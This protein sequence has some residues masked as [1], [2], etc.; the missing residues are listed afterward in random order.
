MNE[1]KMNKRDAFFDNY[2][3]LLI[4]LVVI[5]HFLSPLVL[6]SEFANFI[7]LIGF[8]VNVAGFSF[9]SG[10]FSKKK[11]LKKIFRRLIFP[12]IILQLTYFI[13][14]QMIGVKKDFSL[15]TTSYFSLWYLFSLIVW[16]LLDFIPIQSNKIRIAISLIL[17]FL[18]GFVPSSFN[19]FNLYR[20]VG[21][22]PFFCLGK[23]FNYNKLK[24]MKEKN[25]MKVLGVIIIGAWIYFLFKNSGSLYSHFFNFS[26]PYSHYKFDY[27]YVYRMIYIFIAY[28]LIWTIGLFIPT[29][30]NRLTI[31]G[32]NSLN[33]YLLH[34]F[35]LKYLEYKT[36]IYDLLLKSNGLILIYILS[37][38]GI[39]FLLNKI[40]LDKW[41]DKLYIKTEE[42]IVA[43]KNSIVVLAKKLIKISKEQI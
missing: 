9:I 40:S 42:F 21:F 17:A 38:C 13:F 6:E 23:E 34:G 20:V 28:I 11:D 7:K 14:F 8:S 33:I 10:Y 26:R 37:I 3:A 5:P 24:E 32:R 4:F 12:Y 43:L 41:I 22:Y 30:N 29:Q 39:V 35:L 18:V 2:K 27:P 36:N 31:I 19:E 15:F 16:K 25:Y 1:I